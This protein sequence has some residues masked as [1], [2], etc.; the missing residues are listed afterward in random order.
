ML[1]N[2]DRAVKD[3]LF[4]MYKKDA[5]EHASR[6]T[7]RRTQQIQEERTYLENLRKRE[8]E[9]EEKQK[10]D[11]MQKRNLAREEYYQMMQKKDLLK[12]TRLDDVNFNTYGVSEE[13]KAPTGENEFKPSL[14]HNNQLNL[15]PSSNQ[16]YPTKLRSPNKHEVSKNFIDTDDLVRT[17]RMEQQKAYKTFLDG[18]VIYPLTSR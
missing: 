10:Y 16:T 3:S 8:Q 1:F 15:H 7:E 6:K 5:M 4:Q 9:E 14:Y 17:Y 13:T 12:K 11:K 18:Q 2:A